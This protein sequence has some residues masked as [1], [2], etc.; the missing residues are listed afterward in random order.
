[1][2]A[3]SEKSQSTTP[4]NPEFFGE[5]NPSIVTKIEIVTKRITVAPLNFNIETYNYR[6]IHTKYF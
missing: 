6:A 3:G 4:L 1:V 2:P 5:K